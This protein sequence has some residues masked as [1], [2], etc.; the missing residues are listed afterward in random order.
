[1]QLDKFQIQANTTIDQKL[2]VLVTAPTSSGKTQIAIHAIKKHLTNNKKIIYTSPIKSLSNQKFHEF[3]H[4]FPD[5]EIGLVTGDLKFATTANILIMTTE[6]LRN[7]LFSKAHQNA[8][9]LQVDIQKDVGC[10]VFD[11]MHYINDLQ[12]GQVWEECLIMLPPTVQLILLSATVSNATKIQN[13]LTTIKQKQCALITKKNRV[14]PLQ[15]HAFFKLQIPKNYRNIRDEQWL[16][17]NTNRLTDVRNL[18]Y[19]RKAVARFNQLHVPLSTCVRLLTDHLKKTQKLPVLFFVFSRAQVEQ[20]ATAI[21][22]CFIDNGTEIVKIVKNKLRKLENK[23]FYLQN[24][25]TDALLQLWSRGVAYHHSGL[26]RIYREIVEMLICR[27]FIKVLICTETFAVGLNVPVQTVVFTK[28]DKFTNGAFN[29]I[30]PFEFTQMAGRAGRRGVHQEGHVIILG[31]CPK[32]PAQSR[33]NALLRG[34]LQ[35][36]QTRT[37]Q[38]TYSVYLRLCSDENEMTPARF[39]SLL[40][41]PTD[42]V[43]YQSVITI[44][45]KFLIYHRYISQEDVLLPKGVIASHLPQVNE[46]L[47]TETICQ[48]IFQSLNEQCL[49]AFLSTFLSTVHTDEMIDVHPDEIQQYVT[50]NKLPATLFQPLHWLKLSCSYFESL[51]SINCLNWYPNFFLVPYV[52]KWADGKTD[53]EKI[54]FNGYPANFVKDM[55]LLDNLV[56]N[57]ENIFETLH[58]SLMVQKLQNTHKLIIRGFVN[59]ESLYLF[60]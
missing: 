53:Y 8:L 41:Y 5:T 22:G 32:I 20:L 6:I 29:F 30:E 24:N 33:F 17:N 39:R 46:I 4:T 59:P 38:W 50:K 52:Y 57:L 2:N 7:I 45:R 14:V 34:D 26:D 49:L 44:I 58:N 51:D 9:D 12:R 48:G 18:Y 11:E 42:A 13:W 47:L 27:N 40:L 31:N 54:Q 10:V 28:L 16:K 25:F 23:T 37:F 60:R 36:V 19:L 3:L 43:H 56:T 55:L 35:N 21:K 1:M 15:Y